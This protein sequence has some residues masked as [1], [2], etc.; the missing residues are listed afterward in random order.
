[1][2][3]NSDRAATADRARRFEGQVALITGAATG[4]GLA[5][6]RQLAREGAAVAIVDFNAD[7]L[8]PAEASLREVS[9]RVLAV[10]ANTGSSATAGPN[11]GVAFAQ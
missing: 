2:N 9:D 8:G 10:H 7:A 11:Y 1:V 4:I 6:A 5:T 3:S